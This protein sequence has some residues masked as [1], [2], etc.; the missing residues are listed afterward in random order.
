MKN[1]VNFLE[2]KQT[3]EPIV[4]MTAYDYP[5]ARLAEQQ[6][7]DM[8]LVGDSLGMV[9]LGYDSTVSVTIDDMIHHAKAVRRGAPDTF[10][11]VDMPFGTYHVSTEQAVQ[12]A[13][14]LFQQSNANAIKVEG[15]GELVPAIE[16]IVAAGIP[17]VGHLGLQPQSAEVL[18]GYKVQGNTASS[19]QKLINDAKAL[20]KAGVCAIVFECIPKQLGG[21]LAA[22][23]SVPIIGIGAGVNVDGQVLVYH[24]LLGYGDHRVPKFVEKFSDVHSV[25]AAGIAAYRDGVKA[26]TFP[27]DAQSFTMNEQQLD[28]LYGG[29]IK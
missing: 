22:Q 6:N 24:D 4:M 10:V 29:V 9:V 21:I 28:G 11:V 12:H 27:S 20:E 2:M 19:A 16:R 26:R 13:I 8:I 18:G 23:V 3:G 25:M 15:A 17:V 14:Q 1:V 5:S 7:I